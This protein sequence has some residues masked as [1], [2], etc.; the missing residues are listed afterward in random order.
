MI[1]NEVPFT[2]R[3]AFSVTFAL[4][5]RWLVIAAVPG[6]LLRGFL[7]ASPLGPL[8]Q[9][10]LS[11]FALW[12]AIKWLLGSGRLASM[13]LMFMEQA[14]YQELV[15]NIAVERDAPQVARPSP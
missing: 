2:W 14:H 8:L 15:S 4:F 9:L 1:R 10:L 6:I 7:A 5:W 3:L 12:L 11:F 13:K